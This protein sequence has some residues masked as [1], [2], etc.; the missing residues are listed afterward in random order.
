M[1]AR[2]AVAL[3]GIMWGVLIVAVISLV[4][5]VWLAGL[6][7]G[8]C[9]A[10][11]WE[12]EKEALEQALAQLEAE[13]ARIRLEVAKSRAVVRA[14]LAWKN[15]HQL[16]CSWPARVRTGRPDGNVPEIDSD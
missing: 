7:M 11:V 13:A 1:L 3:E 10:V 15:E 6:I 5:D 4:E 8:P 9:V 2:M 14:A 16:A 12:M